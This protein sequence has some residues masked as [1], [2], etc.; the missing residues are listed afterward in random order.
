[1]CSMC[2]CGSE[3]KNEPHRMIEHKGK[4]FQKISYPLNL[5]INI[6]SYIS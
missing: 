5:Q 1:M 3:N 6:S 2:L 4:N